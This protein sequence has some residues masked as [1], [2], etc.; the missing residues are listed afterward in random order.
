VP[1]STLRPIVRALGGELYAGG[2]R[3]NIPAPGHS[4]ADRSVSLWLKDGRVIVHTFGDGDWRAVMDELRRLRLLDD[5]G[6]PDWDDPP[7]TGQRA[8]ADMSS[9]ERQAVAARVWETGRPVAGTLSE[10]HLRLRA[11]SRDLPGADALRHGSQ[12]PVAAYRDGGYRRPALLAAIRAADGTLAG[13][14]ITYLAPNGRRADDL[15]LPRKTIGV[16][17]PGCAVRLDPAAPEMLVAEGVVT[18]LSAGARF[19]LPAWALTS[20]RNL[21][22]WTPPHGVRAVL[23]AADRGSDGEASAERL[24]RRLVAHGVRARVALPPAGCGDWNDWAAARRA[25]AGPRALEEEG[26]DRAGAPK[27]RMVLVPGAGA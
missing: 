16:V 11:V 2:R 19:A 9:R 25:A 1:V 18:T 20:T 10:R 17:P 21:R 24:R 14:E 4:P 27:D 5:A 8:A 7:P 3:A 15:R 22:T 13:V 23:I 26:R 6:A 12:V